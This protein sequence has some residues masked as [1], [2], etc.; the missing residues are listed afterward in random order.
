MPRR[1][2]LSLVVV[3]FAATGVSMPDIARATGEESLRDRLTYSRAV[4][5]VI[6][7]LPL[8]NFK[9][10]RDGHMEDAG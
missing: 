8:M 7:S 5:A 6:W 1:H 4:E 9:A 10:M 2:L 3:A